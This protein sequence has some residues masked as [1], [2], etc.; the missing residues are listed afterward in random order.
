MAR[1]RDRAPKGTAVKRRVVEAIV[2]WVAVWPA[3]HFGLSEAYGINP[4][5]LFGFAMYSVPGPRGGV[6]LVGLLPDGRAVRLDRQQLS[7]DERALLDRYHSYWSE[8]GELASPSRLVDGVLARRPELESLVVDTIR[9][10]IDRG[11]A[12]VAVDEHRVRHHRD[13]RSETLEVP[14]SHADPGSG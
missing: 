2:V 3:V 12:R 10:R 5:K 11:T 1:T 14:S 13:G 6:R 7:D 8:L 4:W 9:Y